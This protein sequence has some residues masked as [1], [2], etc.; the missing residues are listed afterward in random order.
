[1]A[2][3]ETYPKERSYKDPL[4]NKNEN[5]EKNMDLTPEGSDTAAGAFLPQYL[6]QNA[7]LSILK[8]M[9]VI[10]N[11]D[12]YITCTKCK[13]NKFR[14]IKPSFHVPKDSHYW[15]C[16]RCVQNQNRIDYQQLRQIPSELEYK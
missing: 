9:N 16:A 11:D 2:K 10:I 12:L 13:A 6:D 7:L 3:K 14:V 1:M 15:W 8:R 4:A 5:W